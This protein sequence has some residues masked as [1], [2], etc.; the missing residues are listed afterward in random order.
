LVIRP[1]T[2]EQIPAILELL[3]SCVAFMREAGIDQWDE[4]YPTE[5]TIAADVD[6]GSMYLGTLEDG[7]IAG[8]VVLNERQDPE[9]REVP[10]TIQAPRIGV[11]HRLMVT[12]ALQGRGI[13]ELF[14]RFIEQRARELGYGGLRLD[15]FTSNPRALRLYERLGYHDA[16]SMRLRKGL[17]RGFEKRLR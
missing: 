9:Y 12:P 15:A 1:A 10:W 8:V 6:A 4:V 7:V 14:M 13:A 16:G 5:A 2:R 3:H 17:F 11:V